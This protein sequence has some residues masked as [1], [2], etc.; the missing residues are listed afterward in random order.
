MK[1]SIGEPATG[2]ANDYTCE[3]YGRKVRCLWSK[4][5]MPGS[6]SQISYRARMI[7]YLTLRPSK[8]EDEAIC[9]ANLRSLN[10][11]RI[12]G[13]A[14]RRSKPEGRIGATPSEFSP[15]L[16]PKLAFFSILAVIF[17][18]I[19]RAPSDFTAKTCFFTHFG[20]NFLSNS[21]SPL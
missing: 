9:S 8:H 7:R 5:A 14:K 1:Y 2:A 15:V 17:S 12:A 19:Q 13:A 3:T 20:R 10:V 16:Q 18:R 6:K 4:S 21:A 11:C